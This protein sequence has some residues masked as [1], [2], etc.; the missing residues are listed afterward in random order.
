MV[1]LCP[2]P[3]DSD[4]ILINLSLEEVKEITNNQWN[5]EPTRA[6][7]I[8]RTLS[9][10][11]KLTPLKNKIRF[12]GGVDVSFSKGSDD[13]WA[14]VSVFRYPE[15]LKIET[16]WVK[17][18]AD[19]PYIPGL[20]SFRE[21]PHIIRS[22]R[23]LNILPDVIIC[24]GQGIA[25]PRGMGIA[26]HLGVLMDI[27]TIGCAKT[28]L[29]G[30]FKEPARRK[31]SYSLLKYRGKIVGAVLRS[32]ESVRPIFVSPGHMITLQESIEIVIRCCTRYRLPEPIR[33]A[34]RLVN[35]IRQ[36][37]MAV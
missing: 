22:I 16:R 6:L 19:F 36:S 24:D 14:G 7:E 27:P 30:E 25:H 13:L 21:L 2:L 9:R 15:L 12:V 33:S 18:K 17:G 20:L 5:I 23:E 26:S 8:Q 4:P 34:H 11:V 32:R 35:S 10:K 29:I 28:R 37:E 1:S 3:Y 31:G